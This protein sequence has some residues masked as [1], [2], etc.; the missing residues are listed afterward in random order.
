MNGPSHVTPADGN[1]F[2]DLGFPEPEASQLLAEAEAKLRGCKTSPV[3]SRMCEKG[4][5]SRVVEHGDG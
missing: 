5:K 3:S 2:A 4:T 1:I